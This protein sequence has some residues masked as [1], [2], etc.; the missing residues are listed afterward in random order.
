[1]GRGEF[2]YSSQVPPSISMALEDCRTT[3]LG[4]Y[5]NRSLRFM[6]QVLVPD[7]MP[8]RER[9]FYIFICAS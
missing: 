9:L 5:S 1:M 7:D 2:N 6:L 4:Y 3:L 8:D